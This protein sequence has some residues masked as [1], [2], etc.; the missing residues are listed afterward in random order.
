MAIHRPTYATRRM[1]KSATDIATTADYDQQVDSAL[2]SAA[3]E[4]DS[5]CHRR[6][7][8][9]LATH[10]WDWPN[11]QRAYPWRIWLQ[12]HELADVTSTVPV[13]TTGGKLIPASAL[14][15]GPWESEAPPF[16]FVEIDRST[17]YAFG[18]GST[19]QQ[20]VSITGLYG[21]WNRTRPAGVLAAAISTTGATA[22][23]VSDCSVVDAGDVITVD[24]ETM[25]VA[26]TGMADTGQVQTG[27]GCSTAS[28]ADNQL[29]V[30]DGTKL[31]AQEVIAL[32]GERML[33]TS[34]SGNVATVR[35]GYDG[36]VL[37][38]HT[39]AAVF[40]LRALTVTRGDFGST[41]ATHLNAAAVTAAAVPGD[42][43]ELAAAEALNTTYQKVSA[44]ARTIGENSRP[45]PG[46]SLP[47][48]RAR[49]KRGFYRLR[50][51]VI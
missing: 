19:P 6:F 49:V 29:T 4:V 2:E 51:A 40:A 17:S 32:D 30:A 11:F 16:L 18:V 43:R 41:A 13:V 44:Y 1:V 21:Y 9:T 5:L 26:D 10:L 33:I 31:H 45:V 23:T 48:L 50:L 7:Y 3:D 39:T 35:R 27:G 38:G 25:L 15:W 22:I 36:T 37:A 34:I 47:D 24:T 46:G 28:D 42:V 20:D 8:N 14:K 12:Q